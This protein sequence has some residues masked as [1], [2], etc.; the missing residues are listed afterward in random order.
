MRYILYSLL[1]FTLIFSTLADAKDKGVKNSM[2]KKRAAHLVKKQ[3][4]LT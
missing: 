1:A 3:F 2:G 4:Q